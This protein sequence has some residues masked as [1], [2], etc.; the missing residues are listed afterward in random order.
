[1][2]TK[3]LIIIGSGPA[4]LTAG[5]YAARANLEPLILEGP[6]PGGQL[7]STTDV[8]NWPGE[9]KISGIQLIKNLKEHT[10]HFGCT[11]ISESVEQID[12]SVHPFI[13]TTDKDQQFAA[14]A[15]IT[16]TGATPKRLGSPGEQVYWAKGVSVCAVCEN[17]KWK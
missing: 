14:R 5:L 6:T 17:D 4:G 3:K 7:T 8:E 1:M 2:E 16:A 11:F 15:I 13:I 12:T 10:L 9:K